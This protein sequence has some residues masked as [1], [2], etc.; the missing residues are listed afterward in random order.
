MTESVYESVQVMSF[1]VFIDELDKI[2]IDI[3]NQL[4][5]NT[6]NPHSYVVA[7]KDNLF[8][9]ALHNSDI[10][11][12]DGSGIV[13][14]AKL[15]NKIKIKK[16]TGAD[17]QNHLLYKLNE[18]NGSVFYMGSTPET[19]KLIKSKISKNFPSIKVGTYSP[20]FKPLLSQEDNDLIVK[21]V[22]T[23]SPDVLF[24]GM[25]APKQEKWLY[26][27]KN[28]LNFRI[29][30]SIGAAFDFYSGTV[31]RPSD[32]WI[33]LHLEWLVRFLNEP[34]RLFHRNFV[35]SSIF[36]KDL[37]LYRLKIKR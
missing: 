33:K 37:L 24:I 28:R 8:S 35:S 25:T 14:A 17:I 30:S 15:L 10:V 22:N 1:N 16:I 7:K 12:P 32:F 11:L 26:E 6:L 13:L 18:N 3:N 23:F 27:N 2:T 36:L 20:P 5:I 4:V 29:A 19:L 21:K 34:K 9:E 31:A